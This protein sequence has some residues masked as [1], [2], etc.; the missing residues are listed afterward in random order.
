MA[1]VLQSQAS[2]S[3]QWRAS[4]VDGGI[5]LLLAVVKNG[6]ITEED[7]DSLT[8]RVMHHFN[9]SA[10]DLTG[11]V[12]RM[13]CSPWHICIEGRGGCGKTL[14]G[15]HIS[16]DAARK[17]E[18]AIFLCFN[19]PLAD[20]LAIQLAGTGVHTMT[21]ASL[22]FDYPAEN[23]LDFNPDNPGEFFSRQPD[24][25]LATPPPPEWLF[26][27]I[28]VDEGQDF[29]NNDLR[30]IRH[31][32]HDSTRI[33]WM[34]D[35]LQHLNK[36][37]EMADFPARVTLHMPEN[38]RTARAI[39]DQINQYLELPQP[40]I[41]MSPCQGQ[42]PEI[43]NVSSTGALLDATGQAV[44]RYLE[45]GYRLDQIL[46]LSWEGMQKSRL[47]SLDRLADYS[48]HRFTGTYD[49]QQ[50]QVYTQGD[51]RLETVYRFKGLDADVVIFAELP[52]HQLTTDAYNRNKFYVGMTRA[53][54]RLTLITIDEH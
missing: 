17:G 11:M 48:L 28:V 22:V 45:A 36:Y 47:L 9:Q 37:R 18:R 38:Y 20:E 5:A 4:A 42:I 10:T 46:V 19:R 2:P 15:R 8:M 32:C 50:R 24:N 29:N 3:S 39:V 52:L 14:L 51:L 35:S 34:R 40:M 1:L 53:R 44:A 25:I 23:R 21:L 6:G 43:I 41:S 26:D 13:E 7:I 54:Q 33:L 31:L 27:T 12:Q 30:L 16:V 49:E